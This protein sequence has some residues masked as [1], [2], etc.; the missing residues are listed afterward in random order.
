MNKTLALGEFGQKGGLKESFRFRAFYSILD[1]FFQKLYNLLNCRDQLLCRGEVLCNPWIEPNIYSNGV[2]FFT[3]MS[4]AT[5]NI[6]L[7]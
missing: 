1:T 3:C 6:R 7:E 2:H 4:P 5:Q